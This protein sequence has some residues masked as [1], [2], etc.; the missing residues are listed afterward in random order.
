M[1]QQPRWRQAWA[2]MRIELG[3]AFFS[4]RAFWVYV[5]ALFPS[6]I[7]LGY[8]L[9]VK[10]RTI[11]LSYAGKITPAQLDGIGTGEAAES[12]VERLGKTTRD[13]EWTNARRVREKTEETGVTTHIVEPAYAARFVRLSI[14]SGN[15]AND[16]TARIYE[17]EVYGDGPENLALNRPA[18]G[19]A[20]C[21]PNEGPEKAFNGSVS[22]GFEDRW[23]SQSNNTYLQVD[24]GSAV[25][26]RRLVI[27]HASAGGEPEEFNTSRFSIRAGLDNKNF[28]TIVNS[29]GA[30]LVD[31]ITV[32]RRMTYF[33]G[34]R[35][36]RLDF[37]DGK[38]VSK[39]IDLLRDFEGDR[40]IFAGVFQFFYLRLA[41]FFGCLGIFMNL[42]RG[43]ML[44]RTLH[45]WF[46][47]P[48]RREVLLAGKYG[49]GL[50]ASI[51]IFT[52]GTLICFG[53]MVW[54]HN[55]LEV[56]AFWQSTGKG[57][58]LWYAAAA[59]FGCVGYGSV[60]LTA[61][62]ILRNPII[63]AAILLAWESINGFLPELMQKASILYY[64]QSIC[65]IPAPVNQDMPGIL[66]ILLTPVVPASRSGAIM[67]IFVI[68]AA[69][70]WL[71]RFAIL[72]VQ[73]SYSSE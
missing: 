62:L 4:K 31:E 9:Q 40:R 18:T 22:G 44:D 54:P 24:L 45:Y 17:L 56:Q 26:I 13:F 72:R 36:A 68:T 12:V 2:I 55:S 19:S 47:A 5:L 58:A 28:T 38:L 43:E 25:P 23:C 27:R 7:F 71:A 53:V 6:M 32:H 63:P 8:H 61:G 37:E 51:V 60:F 14:F 69:V 67:G 35:E 65:P 59:V 49:A 73:I 64:L 15:Y 29:T 16:S 41:I 39:T 21:N 3:R 42:F 52:C 10:I 1:K 34:S 30:R 33:D 20:P 48:V 70:L 46:L 11:S 50:I 57:H 66:R